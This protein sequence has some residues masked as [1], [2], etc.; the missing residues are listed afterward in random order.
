MKTRLILPYIF[1]GLAAL[2]RPPAEKARCVDILPANIK[3]KRRSS[4]RIRSHWPIA[5][6][7]AGL[8]GPQPG[9][10]MRDCSTRNRNSGGDE[11]CVAT[12]SQKNGRI[13]V[14]DQVKLPGGIAEASKH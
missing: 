1:A 2:F 3:K 12:S 7:K 8:S 6:V 5:P 11:F 13:S 4:H 14:S 9:G 10:S